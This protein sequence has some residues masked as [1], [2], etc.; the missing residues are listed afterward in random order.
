VSF[1]HKPNRGSLFRSEKKNDDDRDY[2][3]S[4]L[5]NGQLV[6][7]SGWVAESKA[8]QKYLSLSFKLQDGETA[9]STGGGSRQRDMDDGVPF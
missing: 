6:W 8:G 3:G 4:A 2:A 1:T 7:I 9:R 5:I